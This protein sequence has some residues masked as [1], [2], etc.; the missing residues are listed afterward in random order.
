M[1]DDSVY[2]RGGY[3]SGLADAGAHHSLLDVARSLLDSSLGH[4]RWRRIS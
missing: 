1:R 4:A 2:D 3:D